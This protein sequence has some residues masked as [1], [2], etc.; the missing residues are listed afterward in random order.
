MES[1]LIINME[2]IHR[3]A[4]AVVGLNKYTMTLLGKRKKESQS[5]HGSRFSSLEHIG[6]S[7]QDN[8]GLKL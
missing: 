4:P 3:L 2:P 5:K 1:N 8:L 7:V 6:S